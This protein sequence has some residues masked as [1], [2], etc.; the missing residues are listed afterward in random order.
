VR[1]ITTAITLS[2]IAAGPSATGA[3]EQP[4]NPNSA[5]RWHSELVA[6]IERYKRYP[7]EARVRDE[8]GIARIAFTLDRE[9]HLLSSRIVRSSGS[10]ALDR[11]TLEMLARAQPMPRPPAD[12]RDLSFTLPVRFNIT[13]QPLRFTVTK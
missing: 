9:G 4:P 7:I 11:E 1:L 3:A 8:E 2:F 5:A 10:A 13:K 12:A 6:H